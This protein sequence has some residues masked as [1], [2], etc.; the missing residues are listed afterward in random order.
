MKKEFASHFK[1]Y[2]FRMSASR[3]EAF[4]KI[5]D[6]HYFLRIFEDRGLERQESLYFKFGVVVNSPFE[7]SC[8]P[9][10]N[11]V[12]LKEP[13]YGGERTDLWGPS[14]FNELLAAADSIG[15]PWLQEYM[16]LQVLADHISWRIENG[17]K[18]LEPRQYATESAE[19]ANGG[20]DILMLSGGPGTK[21]CHDW[22]KR[23]YKPLAIVQETAG[24][25]ERALESISAYLSHI[26]NESFR[27]DEINSIRKS[28]DSGAWPRSS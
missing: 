15:L 22:V 24:Q 14:E 11:S 21:I 13:C 25:P 9:F 26:S 20:K 23:L 5:D 8:W 18:W 2:G 10:E 6:L 12:Y 27:K 19:M 7:P 1:G 3:G 28:L 4:K 16:D 17:I